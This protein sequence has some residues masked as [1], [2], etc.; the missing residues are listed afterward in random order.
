MVN[1]GR[2][3]QDAVD[4]STVITLVSGKK[5]WAQAYS[6]S[7]KLRWLRLLHRRVNIAWQDCCATRARLTE[8]LDRAPMPSRSAQRRFFWSLSIIR[9]VTVKLHEA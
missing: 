4:V 8:M 7:G 1:G 2:H 9:H 3:E 6:R 5:D